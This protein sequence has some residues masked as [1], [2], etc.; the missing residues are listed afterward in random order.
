LFLK[1]NVHLVLDEDAVI[2]ASMRLD[3]YPQQ[4]T[5]VAGIGMVWPLAVINV[6]DA[7]NV[8][9]S[10]KGTINGRGKPFWDVFW[11]WKPV[12]EANDLRWALDYDC[13]PPKMINCEGMDTFNTP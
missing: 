10:G 3:D 8:A 4:I 9:I 11:N 12:Y 2:L 1:D 6:K 13:K 5:R 7:K